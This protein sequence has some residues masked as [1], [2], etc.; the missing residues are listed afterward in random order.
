M[1]AKGHK[2]SDNAKL[3][4]S[5]AQKGRKH[6][7]QEG[8]MRGHYGFSGTEKTRFKAGV[9]PWNKGKTGVYSIETKLKMGAWQKG[10]KQKQ[11][12]IEKRIKS[13]AGYTHSEET[14]KKISKENNKGLCILHGHIRKT[15]EYGLWRSSV[16]QRDKWACIWCGSKKRIEADHIKSFAHYPELRF[17]IDNG[18]TLCHKCHKT[19]DTYGGKNKKR[20]IR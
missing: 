4:V 16:F 18:R 17:A 20:R 5:L 14:R 9:I 2:L 3:K 12:T 10:K 13:R 11:E 8:F 19:T 1:P 6:T 7:P 15:L